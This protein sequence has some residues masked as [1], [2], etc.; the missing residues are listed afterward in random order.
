MF[1]LQPLWL[2]KGYERRGRRQMFDTPS[3]LTTGN[4]KPQ[5]GAAAGR[6]VTRLG[7]GTAR[8]RSR[9]IIRIAQVHDRLLRHCHFWFKTL[10][11]NLLSIE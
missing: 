8:E 2:E 10:L 11:Y 9:S 1:L 6:R 3:N 7:K 4:E 5:H